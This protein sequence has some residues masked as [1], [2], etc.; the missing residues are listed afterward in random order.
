MSKELISRLQ[1]MAP[2]P[3]K[4][5]VTDNVITKEDATMSQ[6]TNINATVN[7]NSKE[8][9]MN[10]INTNISTGKATEGEFAISY[11]RNGYGALIPIIDGV[12]HKELM[13]GYVSERDAQAGIELLGKALKATNGDIPA[14]MR[15]MYTAASV[16]AN[17]IHTTETVE[18]PELDAEFL[19]DYEKKAIYY[20]DDEKAN[21]DDLDTTNWPNEAIKAMLVTRAKE[22]W[23][24]EEEGADNFLDLFAG[25]M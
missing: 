12:P 8:A 2:K 9:T 22:K 4:N 6:N 18:I 20:Y 16:V 7:A 17:D 15:Y 24:Q 1:A 21:L 3:T 11:Q 25:L 19:I 23:E 10:N 13:M 14:A 5:N